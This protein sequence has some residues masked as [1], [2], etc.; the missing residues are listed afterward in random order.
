MAPERQ[1]AC[2]M[3]WIWRIGV[4]GSAP[5]LQGREITRRDDGVHFLGTLDE[6][7]FGGEKRLDAQS[8]MADVSLAAMAGV[9][10]A[11]HE[12]ISEN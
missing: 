2:G 9:T 7:L 11:D 1:A 3:A 6:V 8:A 10:A 4:A 12:R 5:R